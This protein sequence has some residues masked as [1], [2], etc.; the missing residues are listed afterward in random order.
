[1][2]EIPA[3]IRVKTENFRAINQADTSINGITV[4]A[5]ENGCGKSSISK[6]LYFLYKTV[7]NYD[8]LVKNKLLLDLR[9]AI[10]FLEI[11][12]QELSFNSDERTQRNDFW[13]EITELR[14]NLLNSEYL[15]DELEHWLKMVE[16]LELAYNDSEIQGSERF[17][18]NTTRLE[19]IIKDIFKNENINQAGLSLFS[20]VKVYFDTKFKEAIG[21]IKSRPTSLFT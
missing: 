11:A 1:M 7:S 4:V 19:Y 6:L 17:H 18:Q 3:N 2:S 20:Q 5:G 13:R 10:K 16:K 14:K 15:E 8:L 9:D 12:R 21:K